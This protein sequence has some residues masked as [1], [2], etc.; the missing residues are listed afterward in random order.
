M[1]IHH[2][3]YRI[4][5]F[6]RL[7]QFGHRWGMIPHEA[8]HRLKI[9]HFCARHGPAATGEAFGVS[10]RTLYRWQR[11]LTQA[12]GD[13]QALAV[14]SRAPHRRRQATWPPALSQA[15]RRL[16][17][18]Y[19]NRGKAKLHVLLRPWCAQ[20]GLALPR[21]STIGRLI[22]RAPDRMRHTP[23]R[24]DARGRPKPRTR[25]RKSRPPR[26]RPAQPLAV[27]AGDPVVRLHA[28]LRRYLFTF[29]DPCSRFAFAVATATASSRHAT[30][31]LDAL[32]ALLPAPPRVLLSDNGPEFQGHFQHRLDERGITHWWT[33]PRS[34]KMNAHA[35]RFNR[36]L[37]ETFVDYHEDLLF[38]DLAAFNR[39]LADWLLAYNTVLPHHS[40]GRQSPVQ[41]LIHHQPECQMWWT[42]TQS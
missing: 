39:K 25:R 32:C 26:P 18:T 35:E 11:A 20:H 6:Y 1:Q 7:T 30:H 34:P 12:G 5:G 9:L 3:G 16:R 4:R 28:G 14:R 42:H 22:A 17:T 40:L 24:L 27:L 13:P 8:H 29:I 2:V 33:Y 15:I 23:S 37:Q 41:S 38:D 19:P 36:T 21:V 10:R 31:A